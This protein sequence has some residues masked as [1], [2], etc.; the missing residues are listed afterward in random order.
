MKLA[1]ERASRINLSLSDVG[2][3]QHKGF[4]KNPL[5]CVHPKRRTKGA[6]RS[7]NSWNFK[8]WVRVT[9]YA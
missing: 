1:E 5:S 8:R 7:A 4:I 9:P 6:W 3:V 2:S